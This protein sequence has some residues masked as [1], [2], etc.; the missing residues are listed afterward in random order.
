[1]S[2]SDHFHKASKLVME[3]AIPNKTEVGLKVEREFGLKGSVWRNTSAERLRQSGRK[4]VASTCS[5]T[6][7]F[8]F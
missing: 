5:P 1:M 6:R 4:V 7:S 2:K 8:D 3:F